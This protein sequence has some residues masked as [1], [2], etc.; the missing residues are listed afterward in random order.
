M[1]KTIGPY[2]FHQWQI[3][4][5][6]PSYA[7][8]VQP[9]AP[10]VDGN[11]IFSDA[12]RTPVVRGQT[13]VM[14][15]GNGQTAALFLANYYTMKNDRQPVTIVDQFNVVFRDCLILDVECTPTE[16]VGGVC[17][18]DCLWTIDVPTTL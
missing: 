8:A 14:L 16:L 3:T 9:A 5:P 18:I 2:G 1:A 4:M 6:R 7:L 10:G 17:R 12:L 11:L 13:A 15:S